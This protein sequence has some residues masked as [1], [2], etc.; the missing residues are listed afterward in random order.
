MHM[1]YSMYYVF[2]GHTVN[3]KWKKI[4]D[5]NFGTT[6]QV[7][8]YLRKIID[9]YL[10]CDSGVFFLNCIFFRFWLLQCV[11]CNAEHNIQ[12]KEVCFRVSV[13]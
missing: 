1:S 6:R 7:V 12:R 13:V 4:L 3:L 9:F 8:H 2:V 10:T 11:V 5:I